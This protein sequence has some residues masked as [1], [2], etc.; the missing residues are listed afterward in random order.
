[1]SLILTSTAFQVHA[2]VK[3]KKG[4]GLIRSAA[5]RQTL[6]PDSQ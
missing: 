2:G 1:M 3:P 6:N 5:A 4:G